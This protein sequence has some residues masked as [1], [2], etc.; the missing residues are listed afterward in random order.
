MHIPRIWEKESVEGVNA[1][2][3]KVQACGWGW[4]EDD[5]AEARRRAS[6]S[7]SRILQW[8]LG[9]RA[10][11]EPGR[12]G[13]PDRLPR[14]EIIK[15]YL[16]PQGQPVAFVSRNQYGALILNTRDLMFIDVDEPTP[17]SSKRKGLFA[18]WFGGASAEDST[19]VDNTLN[20]IRETAVGHPDLAFRVYRTHSGYRLMVTNLL[21]E[22]DSARA[23]QLLEDFQADPLYIRMCRNQQCFRA[24]LTPKPWRC[25]IGMPPAKFPFAD[26]AAKEAYRSWEQAYNRKVAG[27]STC[28]LVDVIGDE[29]VDS[30]RSDFLSLHDRLSN[31]DGD[32]PLA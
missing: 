5:V 18:S 17:S 12:Y 13:Y 32:Y 22:A 24:R 3:F 31:V 11:Q 14:E 6:E 29:T 28:Q 10:G 27:F 16:D 30:S 25:Q 20:Q 26:A 15:E 7:A 19:Q 2:G 8:L 9:D 21:L 4:S 23:Q 1:D